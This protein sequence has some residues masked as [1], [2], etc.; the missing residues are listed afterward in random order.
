VLHI[1]LTVLCCFLRFLSTEASSLH[2]NYPASSVLQASPPSQTAGLSLTSC[3]LIH[4]AITAGTSRVAHDPLCLHA[5]A[6]TPAGLMELVRSYD[7]T[8]FGLPSNRD[9][10]APALRF[11]RPAQRLLTLRPACSPGRLSDPLHQ[12]LQRS[13]CLHCCSDCYRVERTS[14]RAGH[15]RCGPPPFHG[16]PGN[17]VNQDLDFMARKRKSKSE[18]EM[19]LD[20]DR[21]T[22]L[23]L[24]CSW[25]R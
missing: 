5:V 15:S 23:P 1:S 7:S 19:C 24:V 6:N 12:R 20:V 22:R 11:S 14:S 8:N 21:R 9:G 2:R 17:R 25:L 10:S 18:T 16:A 3:Q 13:R 4:T